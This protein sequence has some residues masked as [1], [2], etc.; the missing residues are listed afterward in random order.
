MKNI[1]I[2]TP[3]YRHWMRETLIRYYAPMGII[4]HPVMYQDQASEGY[5]FTEPWIEPCV[6]PFNSTDEGVIHKYDYFMDTHK[7]VDEDYY[8]MQADDSMYEANVFD[9]IKQL[10]DD[11]VIISCKRGDNIPLGV[12]MRRSYST[13]TLLACPENVHVGGI[14]QCQIFV[15]GKYS[16]LY[17]LDFMHGAPDGLMA[18]YFKANYNV[19]YEPDLYG[20][21]NYFE[22]DRWDEVK[23]KGEDKAWPIPTGNKADDALSVGY[24]LRDDG[25]CG[26]YRLALPINTLS[27]RCK[28]VVTG[29]TK[30]D[31]A[32]KIFDVISSDI[33]VIPRGADEYSIKFIPR[34]KDQSKK[35]VID[36]DDNLFEVSPFNP[37]YQEW[38]V[39]PVSVRHEGQIIPMWVS[40]NDADKYRDMKPQP[41][42]IDFDDNKAR[43]EALKECIRLADMI[44]VTQPILADVYRQYNDNVK[45]LPNCI[46]MTLW[47]KLPFQKH[48]DIRLY[49]AGGW[50]HYEDWCLI[51]D[52]RSPGPQ[53]DG[54][55]KT[56]ECI[57]GPDSQTPR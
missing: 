38:G 45:V 8:V 7:Y 29:F 2:I 23:A 41:Q 9:R 44:T 6:A 54:R 56:C 42:F 12:G 46:D 21:F 26:Y 5:Q 10:D 3:H 19:R 34:L 57:G 11:V 31:N 40:K 17:R 33:I 27:H 50:S 1:H 28:S 15:K 47:Q 51:S 18:E 39:H 48:D 25:A 14:D 16:K 36:Y 20:L 52:D 53:R 32:D 55:E 37:S 22:P 35:I 43:L 13:E 4:W 30:G 24:M 49:W